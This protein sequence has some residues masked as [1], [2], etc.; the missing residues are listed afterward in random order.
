MTNE[1]ESQ[2]DGRKTPEFRERM[3]EIALQRPRSDGQFTSE[4][5]ENQFGSSSRGSF[6]RRGS[7]SQGS[8]STSGSGSRSRSRSSSLSLMA[9]SDGSMISTSRNRSQ[10]GTGEI[11]VKETHTQMRTLEKIWKE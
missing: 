5:S 4:D 1:N 9:D 2:T 10:T 8:R 7:R 11:I 6:S 3:R